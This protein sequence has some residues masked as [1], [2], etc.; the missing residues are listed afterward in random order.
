MA[1]LAEERGYVRISSKAVSRLTML[2]VNRR[3]VG[4]SWLAIAGETRDSSQNQ[5]WFAIVGEDVTKAAV[6]AVCTS[7][8]STGLESLARVTLYLMDEKRNRRFVLLERRLPI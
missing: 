7:I 6:G 8:F 3:L 1:G 5:T 2:L 4:T